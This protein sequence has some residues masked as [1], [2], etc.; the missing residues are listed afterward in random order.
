MPKYCPKC[1]QEILPY[2]KTGELKQI[3]SFHLISYQLYF[4]INCKVVYYEEHEKLEFIYLNKKEE[5]NASTIVET[6]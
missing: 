6:K 2:L 1:N 4:C 5:E 3:D